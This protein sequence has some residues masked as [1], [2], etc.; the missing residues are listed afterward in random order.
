MSEFVNL[1]DVVFGLRT[2]HDVV[3][4]TDDGKFEGRYG[5]KYRVKSVDIAMVV[6]AIEDEN[7]KLYCFD[8]FGRFGIGNGEA[9][10]EAIVLLARYRHVLLFDNPNDIAEHTD[11]LGDA[12]MTPDW[13]AFGWP[14]DELPDFE[15]CYEKWKLENNPS[16]KEPALRQARPDKPRSNNS[17]WSMAEGLMRMVIHQELL[18]KDQSIDEYVAELM[19]KKNSKDTMILLDTLER[20]APGFFDIDETTFRKQL[21][22]I[23][24]N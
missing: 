5:S 9:K 4:E 10:E 18:A 12:D 17:I 14:A 8:D 19:S 23:L 1:Y 22:N 24:R 3:V 21:K 13:H 16:G 7:C 20:L 11:Y 2:T 15:A 6:C